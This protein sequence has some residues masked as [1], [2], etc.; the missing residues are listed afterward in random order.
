MPISLCM[1]VK[2]EEMN[3]PR[4][5]ESVKD[6]VSE[7]IIV[8]TGSTDKT[9][10]IAKSFGA[11]VHHF[12]W[13]GSFSDARNHSLKQ[14]AHDWIMI[15]DAD[16]ELEASGK[17]RIM[18]LIA[19]GDADAY[20]F[21]TISYVG[22]KPG[23]DVLKNMNLRL[24]RNGKGYYYSNPI[25]EQ[26]Y[27]N[28]KAIN[29]QAK[30][31]NETVKVYHYGYLNKNIADHDKRVRNITL[32]EK[33]LEEKPGFPFALFNLGSEY[34]ALGDNIKAISYFED[35]Y[36][37]FNPKEGFSSHLI[38]KMSNCYLALGRLDD[39]EQICKD[40]LKLFPKF[41]D[42]EYMRGLAQ[43][44]AG[45]QLSA[46]NHFQNCLKMG[47][48][49]SVLN[50]IIGAGTFRAGFMLGEMY[51]T[52]E[53]YALAAE[54]YLSCLSMNTHFTA[55]LPKALRALCRQKAGSL[56]LKS[57][58]HTLDN[59]GISSFPSTLADILID[60][61][62]YDLALDSILKKEKSQGANAYTRFAKGLCKLYLK[63]Y[64]A[65]FRAVSQAQ[66]DEQ[67]AQK[68]ACIKVLCKL[69]EGDI[70]L[71][72]RCVHELDNEVT[73]KTYSA[74]IRV[75]KGETAPVLCEDAIQSRYYT[76]TI[77][78]ILKVF[79]V[80]HQFDNFE[81][82]LGLFNLVEDNTV[83]LRLAKLYYQEGCFK[84]AHQELIRSIKL[85][86][87]LDAD[88]AG[89]LKKLKVMGF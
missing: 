31:V 10:E 55:A 41:T 67:Y 81:K 66:T 18:E 19:H 34:Q 6:I 71:A 46:I 43:N 12:P 27:S 2:N 22:E 76:D 37:K 47:E 56:L 72:E 60:E 69:S 30:I 8:D 24:L 3:L 13:N 84:L 29:P 77:F 48:A 4:C 14:A 44:A 73:F 35:A 88:G 85:F 1:I 65:S 70:R 82:A 51:Y 75:L 21:E 58:I 78:E 63:K 23:V 54:S 59:L 80:T 26:I 42:L 36:R 9:V 32:L 38:L 57:N 5:L 68:A 62:Y 17:Q 53:E 25:H 83:L 61:K 87:R 86:D 40:G 7:M 39:A 45:R 64:G 50:V 15:M 11:S 74:L 16:D 49:P 52:L 33:E 20:F 28:I 79:L 89:M